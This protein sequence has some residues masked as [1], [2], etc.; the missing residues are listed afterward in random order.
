MIATRA[1][2]AAARAAVA[3]LGAALDALEAS[4]GDGADELVELRGGWQ[5]VPGEALV[6]WARS[7]RLVAFEAE[8][9]R[10]VAWSSDLRRAVE[11]QPARPLRAVEPEADPLG[12][13]LA[14]GDLR[15][16]GAR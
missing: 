11:A 8:R 6:R 13:A 4:L 3:G 7:G 15:A 14:S 1:A 5:G 12:R 10:L 2:L 16:G 9:G